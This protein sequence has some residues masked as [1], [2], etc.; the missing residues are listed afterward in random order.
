M[1][2][3][4][5]E[6]ETDAHGEGEGGSSV[7]LRAVHGDE[8]DEGDDETDLGVGRSGDGDESLL[9]GLLTFL[10]FRCGVHRSFVSWHV[11]YVIC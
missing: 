11:S 1:V 7:L 4:V 2:I 10:G 9:Q 6:P 8:G 5:G 3:H